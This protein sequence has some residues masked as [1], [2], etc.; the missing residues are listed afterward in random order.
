MQVSSLASKQGATFQYRLSLETLL[1]DDLL[2]PPPFR[3]IRKIF[4]EWTPDIFP[5]SLSDYSRK[6]LFDIV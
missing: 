3:L 5:Q 6:L 1:Y 4:D 2:F